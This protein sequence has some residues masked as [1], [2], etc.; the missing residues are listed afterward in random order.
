MKTARLIYGVA[1]AYGFL[2]LTLGLLAEALPG[3]TS[4]AVGN[5]PEF[6]YGFFATTDDHID[7]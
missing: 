5:K 1:A 7:F 2:V 4:S 3:Q 6:Y